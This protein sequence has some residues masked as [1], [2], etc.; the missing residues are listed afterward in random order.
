MP[1]DYATNSDEIAIPRGAKRI[2][3]AR[4][5]LVAKVCLNSLMNEEDLR[6]EIRSAFHD[7]MGAKNDFHFKFLQSVGGGCRTLFDPSTS[8]T[9]EWNAK[10]LVQSAGC[11]AIYIQAEEKLTLPQH[12]VIDVDADDSSLSTTAT[13]LPRYVHLCLIKLWY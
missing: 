7:A 5:G 11:G 9:F 6:T 13:D 3:L 8:S 10:E 1:Q 2:T 4:Q 12:P